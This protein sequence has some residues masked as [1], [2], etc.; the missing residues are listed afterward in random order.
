[1]KFAVY[2]IQGVGTTKTEH[3]LQSS[4]R[5]EAVKRD[6]GSMDRWMAEMGI[7]ITFHSSARFVIYEN[8]RPSLV[9]EVMGAGSRGWQK[10]SVPITYLKGN[11]FEVANL[12]IRIEPHDYLM[13]T[14][15]GKTVSGVALAT[16]KAG[17]KWAMKFISGQDATIDPVTGAV[18]LKPQPRIVFHAAASSFPS[19]IN[20]KD[21]CDKIMGKALELSSKPTSG[22]M[23]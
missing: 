2:L 13:F 8:G 5:L 16:K 1:M 17:D 23:L 14:Q 18:D 7:A 12:P 19:D 21:W 15:D 22:F 4:D 10:F 3:F 6:K 9:K 20:M 11:D